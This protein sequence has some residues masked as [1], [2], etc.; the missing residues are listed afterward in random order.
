[1]TTYINKNEILIKFDAYDDPMLE[2]EPELKIEPVAMDEEGSE[3]GC[4]NRG[5]S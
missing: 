2:T 5:V 3:H 4:L 1:M